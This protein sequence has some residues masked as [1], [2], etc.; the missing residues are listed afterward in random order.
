MTLTK[1][2]IA[3]K[4]VS[5]AAEI[6]DTTEKD[7]IGQSRFNEHIEPR[8]AVVWVLDKIGMGPCEIGRRMGGRD[9]STISSAIKQA[10]VFAEYRDGFSDALVDLL[11]T[12]IP[13]LSQ[14]IEVPQRKIVRDREAA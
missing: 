2:L 11:D 6:F 7:I 9:H 8:F 10:V 4:L 1:P 14:S 3:K 5:R 13:G 12:A